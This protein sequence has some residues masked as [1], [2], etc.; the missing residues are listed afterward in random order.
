M[1]FHNKHKNTRHKT[2]NREQP[3]TQHNIET[4]PHGI[5]TPQP[6]S[7][8]ISRLHY[9][10]MESASPSEILERYHSAVKIQYVTEIPLNPQA[11][12]QSKNFSGKK[13]SLLR[14]KEFQEKHGMVED[15]IVDHAKEWK[16]LEDI[17]KGTKEPVNVRTIYPTLGWVLIRDLSQAFYDSVLM[18]DAEWFR[19][20]FQREVG[21]DE[22]VLNQWNFF[23][24]FF[25]GPT[26]FECW[27]NCGGEHLVEFTHTS[28]T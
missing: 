26:V 4:Q 15:E 12:L 21:K 27:R 20:K 2:E 18:D 17:A 16:Q 22:E 24:E 23:V 10:N 5:T 3:I 13:A 11:E 25:V 7:R 14:L 8:E 9:N 1:Q 28:Q 19:E 6:T